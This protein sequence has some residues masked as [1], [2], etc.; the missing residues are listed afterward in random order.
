RARANGDSPRGA[1]ADR[2]VW[3]FCCALADHHRVRMV[4]PPMALLPAVAPLTEELRKRVSMVSTLTRVRYRDASRSPAHRLYD[5]T[6]DRDATGACRAERG[7]LPV[8]TKVAG[9]IL[10]RGGAGGAGRAAL[11]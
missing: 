11:R 1:G 7:G 8:T 10:L 5:R 3:R 4:P 9:G 6:T 2:A